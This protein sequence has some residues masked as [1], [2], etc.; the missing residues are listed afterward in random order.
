MSRK[1]ALVAAAFL[2]FF[3][4]TL[5]ASYIVVMKDGTRYRAKEK[6]TIVDGKAML[7]LENGQTLS[8]EAG[9][10]DVARTDE[11]NRSGLGDVRVIATPTPRTQAAAERTPESSLGA[12]TRIRRMEEPQ[13]NAPA[14]PAR[15]TASAAIRP[16]VI[17]RFNSAYENIGLYGARIVSTSSSTI[18]VELVTETEEQVFN[19]L[20]ATALLVNRLPGITSTKIDSVDLMMT[21]IKGS[22]A[23][24]FVMTSSDAEAVD[25]REIPVQKYFVDKVIF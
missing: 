1:T 7:A 17:G 8:I 25:K 15:T 9:L 4:A 10:I 13:A 11:V 2:I 14:N 22:S 3:S 12:L 16:E 20:L 23:G 18:K 6:W 5:Q 24:R 21:T 19:A